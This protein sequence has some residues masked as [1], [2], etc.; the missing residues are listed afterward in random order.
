[1]EDIN[2]LGGEA[3][4]WV[5][6]IDCRMVWMAFIYNIESMEYP[7]ATMF[8]DEQVGGRVDV[9]NPV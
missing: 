3:E 7:R 1:V 5:K 6:L 8:I 9:G 4:R 2:I